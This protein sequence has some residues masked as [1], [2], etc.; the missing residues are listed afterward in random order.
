[1]IKRQSDGVHLFCTSCGTKVNQVFQDNL[2]TYLYMQNSG[3]LHEI[4]RGQWYEYCPTC[5]D[6]REA[7]AWKGEI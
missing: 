4:E 5:L 3:W 6:N 2:E 7:S 1:M